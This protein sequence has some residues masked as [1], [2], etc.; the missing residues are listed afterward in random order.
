MDS[1]SN[2]AEDKLINETELKDIIAKLATTS[3]KSMVKL[4]VGSTRYNTTIA[5]LTREKK[6]FLYNTFF[7]TMAHRKKSTR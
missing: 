1:I 7:Q 6:Y 2:V 3:I 5:T 4:N